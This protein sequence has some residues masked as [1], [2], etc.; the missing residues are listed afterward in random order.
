VAAPSS[1][2]WSRVSSI[3]VDETDAEADVAAAARGDADAVD[4]AAERDLLWFDVSELDGL[5]SLWPR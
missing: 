2:P 4:R 5:R 1:V 3:H